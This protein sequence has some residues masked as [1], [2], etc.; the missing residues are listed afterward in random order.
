MAG[1]WVRV[2]FQLLSLFPC[3]EAK[4]IFCFLSLGKKV[5]PPG[6]NGPPGPPGAPGPQGPPGIPGIPGI[7]GTTVM[8]PPG[9]PGPPG[10]QGQPGLQGPSGKCL[11]WEPCAHFFI[12]VMCLG[13]TPL[14]LMELIDNSVNPAGLAPSGLTPMSVCL[15]GLWP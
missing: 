1:C 14:R 7:P 2:R 6:P 12:T 4:I 3:S 15:S 13:A 5:G 10:P 8:G 11:E 9:P